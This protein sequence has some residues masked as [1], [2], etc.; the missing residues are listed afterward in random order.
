LKGL[1]DAEGS[2]SPSR[3]NCLQISFKNYDEEIRE[4]YSRICQHLDLDHHIYNN[5]VRIHRTKDVLR[6]I[7]EIGITVK[8]KLTEEI[9]K[10][11]RNFEPSKGRLNGARKRRNLLEKIGNL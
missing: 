8:R 6:F 1:W 11:L 5:Q 3:V 2:I 10:N 9:K 4:L 7:E